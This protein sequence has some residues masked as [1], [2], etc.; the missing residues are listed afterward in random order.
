MLSVYNYEYIEFNDKE[1]SLHWNMTAAATDR[2]ESRE[3]KESA[4]EVGEDN[5]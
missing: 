1:S 5:T 3:R 2:K 4:L